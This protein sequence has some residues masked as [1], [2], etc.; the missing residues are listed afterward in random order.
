MPGDRSTLRLLTYNIHG[1]VGRGGIEDSE[2]VLGVIE[3]ANADV[4][5]LQEVHDDDA[6]DL[7]FLRGLERMEYKEVIYGETLRK[8]FGPYGNVLMSRY[9][10]ADMER[11]DLSI[12]GAE[13]RGAIC[14][15]L[16]TRLGRTHVTATHLGLKCSERRRQIEQLLERKAASESDCSVLMGDFNEW[17]P[18]SRNLRRIEGA[19]FRSGKQATFPARFPLFALD[20]IY[21]TAPMLNVVFNRIDTRNARE[22]SDHR[23]LLAEISWNGASDAFSSFHG[24]G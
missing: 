10:L 4:V 23:P 11:L 1:C 21:V 14:A 18:W 5:A 24:S 13:P 8:D 15:T 12:A 20:R 22:A 9:P 3:S 6:A 16:E 2:R 19:F 7:N 17:F